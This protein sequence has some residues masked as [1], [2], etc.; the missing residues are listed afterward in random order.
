MY[1]QC[2]TQVMVGRVRQFT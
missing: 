2:Q 1:D